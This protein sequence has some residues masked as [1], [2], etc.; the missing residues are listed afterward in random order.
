M[1]RD[2]S[3][4]KSE[5]IEDIVGGIDIDTGIPPVE[6]DTED[7][8]DKAIVLAQAIVENFCKDDDVKE[9]ILTQPKLRKQID[10][11][12]ESL[13]ILIKMQKADEITHDMAVKAIGQNCTNASMYSALTKQQAQLIAIQK[14]IDETIEKLQS[15]LKNYQLELN[16]TQTAAREAEDTNKI[17]RGGK[18]W[19]KSVERLEADDTS[20]EDIA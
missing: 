8:N 5:V 15:I 16:F 3:N 9:L 13:R 1:A 18:E 12:I 4:I 11:T 14:Q 17:S 6:I 7:L 20:K 2:K 10:T 19:L